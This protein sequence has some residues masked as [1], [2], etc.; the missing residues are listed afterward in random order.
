VGPARLQLAL[1][2]RGDRPRVRI[3]NE[4]RE[5]AIARLAQASRE[6]EERAGADAGEELAAVID[7]PQ[8]RLL[9]GLDRRA[10][11]RVVELGSREVAHRLA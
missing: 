9:G 1:D 5:L 11:E 4:D 2:R 8:H 3:V 6:G 10:G 7:A